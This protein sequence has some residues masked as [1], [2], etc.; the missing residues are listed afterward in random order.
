MSIGSRRAVIV[1]R[2]AAKLAENNRA[3]MANADG[4]TTK[5]RQHDRVGTACPF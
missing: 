4:M 1:S 5:L 3:G 2:A